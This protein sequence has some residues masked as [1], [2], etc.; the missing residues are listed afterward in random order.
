MIKIINWFL[1]KI[2]GGRNHGGNLWS[3]C[4]FCRRITKI[5]CLINIKSMESRVKTINI[6]MDKNIYCLT[7]CKN[8]QKSMELTQI[9]KTDIEFWT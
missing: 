2:L 1:G 9:N 5:D 4:R 7:C 3:Y 8:L 6:T